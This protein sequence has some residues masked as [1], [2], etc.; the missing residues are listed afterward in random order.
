VTV[1]IS[2]HGTERH[3]IERNLGQRLQAGGVGL[4]FLLDSVHCTTVRVGIGCVGMVAGLEVLGPDDLIIELGRAEG[5]EVR[6]HG[7]PR[8]SERGVVVVRQAELGA[9][10]LDHGAHV[11]VQVNGVGREEVV[12][13]LVVQ[14]TGHEVAQQRTRS[15]V[16]RSQHLL[17]RPMRVRAVPARPEYD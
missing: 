3:P 10:L 12:L 17:V 9:D 7:P 13:D 11:R 4:N 2:D 14:A 16:G 1:A 5:A 6:H 15:P 8:V